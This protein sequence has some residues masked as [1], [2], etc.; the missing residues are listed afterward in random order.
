MKFLE[1]GLLGSQTTQMQAATSPGTCGSSARFEELREQIVA[2]AHRSDLPGRTVA[3]RSTRR[4]L[5]RREEAR[6]KLSLIAQEVARLVTT[7]VA[8]AATVTKNFQACVPAAVADVEQQLQRLFGKRFLVAT[9]P[10][11]LVHYPRYLKAIGA[12]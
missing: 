9:P 5:A 12:D 10:A 8:E 11:Q 3:D 2:A 7:I 6:G 1:K 4:F